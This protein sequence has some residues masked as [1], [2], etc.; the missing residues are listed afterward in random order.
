MPTNIRIFSR[1]LIRSKKRLFLNIILLMAAT[2]FFIMSLNLYHNSTANLQRVEETY[3]TIATVTFFGDMNSQGE[4][5]DPEAEDF[6]GYGT[7]LPRDYDLTPLLDFDYVKGLNRSI[8]CEAY[9]PG[10]AAVST[11]AGESLHESLIKYDKVNADAIY[12]NGNELMLRFTVDSE[13]PIQV[14]L[15]QDERGRWQLERRGVTLPVKVTDSTMDEIS[16]PKEIRLAFSLEEADIRRLNRTEDTHQLTLYPGVEYIYSGYHSIYFNKEPES[17]T[18]TYSV[19]YSY[20]GHAANGGQ[21]TLY[22]SLPDYLYDSW[23][24]YFGEGNPYYRREPESDT[25]PFMFQRWEDV[26][27]D[28]AAAAQ[29]ETLWQGVEYNNYSFSVTL[30]DNIAS[31]PAWHL[32][33]LY[34]NEG[35][36]IT[37]EEYESGAKVCMITGK[38]ADLQ[39]WKVGDKLDMHLFSNLE[40]TADIGT[41]FLDYP[42]YNYTTR[43]FFDVNTYEIVGILGQREILGTSMEAP[44]PFYQPWN[45]IYIPTASA[46]HAPA[47]ELQPLQPSLLSIQ[48]ENG[49]LDAY[50]KDMKALGVTEKTEGEYTLEIH[51]YDQG[52]SIV[53]PGLVRMR[54]SAQLLLILSVVLLLT[55]LVL[56]AYF[57][58]QHQKVSAGILRM[59]GGTKQQVFAGI[60]VCALLVVLVGAAVGGIS[61]GLLSQSVGQRIMAAEEARQ[62]ALKEF[63]TELIND[64]NTAANGIS[65]GADLLI[66][67]LGALGI[68]CGFL[69]LLGLFVGNYL[70][71]EPRELLAQRR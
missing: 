53:Q 55:T 33:G 44:D 9:I 17:G 29:W 49:T 34:L 25:S 38:M 23:V 41:E 42:G 8:R 4:L 22:E 35:R 52:Y 48:L 40:Y 59:L 46:P 16:Y 64:R 37:P 56:V 32:S 31:L 50:L 65:V 39:G 30:T 2:A 54:S 5:T 11:T 70:K 14:P 45:T 7:I 60:L 12:L 66:T 27:S 19:N 1:Q 15:T 20:S 57:F 68:I 63:S 28:P 26:Q 69:I 18:L 43:E 47:A 62:E 51:C 24:G 67:G 13:E 3:S 36:L 71:I 58:A 61:G 10:T 21:F 6:I